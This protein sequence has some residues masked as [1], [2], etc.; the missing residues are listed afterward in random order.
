MLNGLVE[1]PSGTKIWHQNDK[2]HRI[3]GPAV[4]RAN[5]T[6][7]WYINGKE[8]SFTNY[9]IEL[10]LSKEQICELALTYA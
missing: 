4:E 5:G 1:F 7:E 8:Y 10:K 2:L 9:C 3:D 6:K